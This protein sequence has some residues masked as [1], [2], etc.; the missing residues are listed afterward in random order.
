MQ[1][2]DILFIVLAVCSIFIS[3]P[4]ML[5]LWRVYKMMD[6]IEKLFSYADHVR[7]LAMEFEK[8]PMRFVEGL[9]NSLVSKKK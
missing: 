3:V 4:L 6:R 1:S 9:V 5:V 7:G 8:M 2:Q